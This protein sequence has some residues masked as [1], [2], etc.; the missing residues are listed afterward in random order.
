MKIKNSNKLISAIIMTLIGVLFLIK[1]AEVISIVMTVF[2][3][4]L[5][6][7]AVLDVLA[8]DV[9]SCVIK[10]VVGV[11]IILFGWILV[12]IATIILGIA[13]LIYGTLRLIDCVKGF[14]DQKST[15][16]KIVELI[17]PAICVLVGVSVF[18][19]SFGTIA[20]IAF[21]IAGIFLILHGVLDLVDCIA[22]K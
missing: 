5:I 7:Q 1:K 8:K 19:G 6:V 14:K 13:L 20:N 17:L 21:I 22:S 18:I 9:V 15:V 2:G 16:A 11:A 12:D 3:V 10:G 4:M